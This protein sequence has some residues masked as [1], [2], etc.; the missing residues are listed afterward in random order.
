MMKNGKHRSKGVCPSGAHK[1]PLGDTWGTQN[2]INYIN[3][4]TSLCPLCTLFFNKINNIIIIYTPGGH[5][6]F[7]FVFSLNR[8]TQAHKSIITCQINK[9]S[10]KSGGTQEVHGAHSFLNREGCHG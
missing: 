2:N 8:G 9:L 5:F 1:A 6:S 10:Q 3:R 4:L 7:L